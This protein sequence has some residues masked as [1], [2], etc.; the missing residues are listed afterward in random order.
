M[1]ADSFRKIHRARERKFGISLP[2]LFSGQK[3]KF[4]ARRVSYF[5]R[6]VTDSFRLGS[7]WFQIK[8]CRFVL[9]SLIFQSDSAA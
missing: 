6:L 8:T 3:R 1:Q 2:Q 5:A 4:P 9:T 7:Y